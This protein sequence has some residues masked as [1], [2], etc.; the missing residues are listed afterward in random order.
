MTV[1]NSDITIEILKGIRDEIRET[2]QRVDHME[3]R[4][5]G[6]MDELGTRLDTRIDTLTRRVTES[7]IRTATALAE[8]NGTMREVRDLLRD[9]FD[10]RDRVERCERDIEELK[11][12][13]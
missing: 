11:R 1:D 13:H 3:N 2:N 4:L 5:D 7:E 10:L 6:R 9:R 12:R 8:A